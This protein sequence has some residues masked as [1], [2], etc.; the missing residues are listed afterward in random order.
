MN[1]FI[2]LIPFILI[3]FGLLSILNQKAIKRAA[4]FSP[5][6]GIEKVMYWIYQISNIGILVCMFIIKIDIEQSLLFYTGLIIYLFGL[7]LLVLS[8]INFAKPSKDGL[9]LNG[10]YRLSRNPMYLSYF[11]YFIG[12]IVLT[13]SIILLALVSV[14][15]IASHWIILSEERWCIKKFGNE[16]LT[17]MKKVR[18]YI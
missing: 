17:Y 6:I 14:F 11:T 10:L 12:C 18:R 4:H 9:N 3:R 2:L 1:S 7:V 16:Y 13:R 5:M 8:V 15:Q